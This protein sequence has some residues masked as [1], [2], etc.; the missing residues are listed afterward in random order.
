MGDNII[1][2]ETAWFPKDQTMTVPKPPDPTRNNDDETNN[3]VIFSMANADMGSLNRFLHAGRVLPLD[4]NTYC[5]Q[6]AI[7]DQ[8]AIT[9]PI[10]EKVD[11]VITVYNNVSLQRS[12]MPCYP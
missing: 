11:G 10:W 7:L 12:L 3:T 6:A 4:R 5:L 1:D 8:N 2:D 9:Q